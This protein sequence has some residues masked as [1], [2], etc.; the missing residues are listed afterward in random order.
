MRAVTGI[1]GSA[2]ASQKLRSQ[3]I[4]PAT[5]LLALLE[6]GLIYL[7]FDAQYVFIFTQKDPRAASPIEAVMLDAGMVILSALG[8]GLAQAGPTF[9]LRQLAA[10]L[11]PAEAD[12]DQPVG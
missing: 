1:R 4:A 6:A 10:S 8:I 3:V 2:G 7:S 9:P 11:K 5:W 12:D